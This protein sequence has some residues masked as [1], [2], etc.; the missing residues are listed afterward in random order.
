MH[1]AQRGQPG[2][3]VTYRRRVSLEGVVVWWAVGVQGQVRGRDILDR[4]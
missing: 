1:I 2:E 3:K 4:D